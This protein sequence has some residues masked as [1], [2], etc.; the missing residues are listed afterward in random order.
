MTDPMPD[1]ARWNPDGPPQNFEW[2]AIAAAM[3]GIGRQFA[4]AW[5][6]IL[7]AFNAS[8]KQA[9]ENVTASGLA[10]QKLGFAIQIRNGARPCPHRSLYEACDFCYPAPNP[11]ARDYR[12][13]TKHRRGRQR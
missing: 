6:G 7:A 13:P 3:E 9:L 4:E 1:A 8:F 11:A 12:R 10:L 5:P 2:P